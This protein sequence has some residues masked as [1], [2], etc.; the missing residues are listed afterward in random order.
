[1]CQG[2][3]TACV[4]KDTVDKIV[5]EAVPII[6]CIDSFSLFECPVKLGTT[7]EKRLM[8]DIK[9]LRQVYERRDIAEI[10]WITGESNPADALTKYE[11]NQ[12][13]EQLINSN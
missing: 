5:D 6:I 1:M 9:A 2:F 4:L 13:L 12:A 7:R 3:D 11:G 8:I 10:I